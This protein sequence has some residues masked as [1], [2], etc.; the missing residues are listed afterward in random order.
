MNLSSPVCLSLSTLKDTIVTIQS[1]REQKHDLILYYF[2]PTQIYILVVRGVN[3]EYSLS[4]A[5][6]LSL[7][8]DTAEGSLTLRVGTVKQSVH[9]DTC[10][11]FVHFGARQGGRDEW[12][13]GEE[14]VERIRQ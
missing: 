6:F 4:K 1:P 9:S 5:E 11:L 8:M 10:R 2:S 13:V 14:S 12:R 3:S 7:M